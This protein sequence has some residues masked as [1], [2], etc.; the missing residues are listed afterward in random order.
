MLTNAEHS[1]RYR[2]LRQISP[3]EGEERGRP[4]Q[5]VAFDFLALS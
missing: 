4:E 3:L 5:L 2:Y 1:N